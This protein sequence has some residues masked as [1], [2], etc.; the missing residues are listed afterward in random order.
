MGRGKARPYVRRAGQNTYY[1][2]S[3]FAEENDDGNEDFDD[4]Y[5]REDWE[6]ASMGVHMKNESKYDY[7]QHLRSMGTTPGAVFIPAFS[8]PHANQDQFAVKIKDEDELD[9]SGEESSEE[10]S[11]LTEYDI[12]KQEAQRKYEDEL[13]RLRAKNAELDEVMRLLEETE[14]NIDVASETRSAVPLSEEEFEL[15][16]DFVLLAGMGSAAKANGATDFGEE[17]LD[18]FEDQ[19][20]LSLEELG[21][22]ARL[23]DEQFDLLNMEYDSDM[24]DYHEGA[25][26]G[27]EDDKDYGDADYDDERDEDLLQRLGGENAVD[28]LLKDCIKLKIDKPEEGHYRYELSEDEKVNLKEKYKYESG[29][30][31]GW[32]SDPFLES[33]EIAA[34]AASKK[35]QWDCETILTTYTNTENHPSVIGLPR[36][37]RNNN[38]KMKPRNEMLIE[39]ESDSESSDDNQFLESN[40]GDFV[41][42]ASFKKDRVRGESK[43][44]KKLRKAA[45]KEEKRIRRMQ[46]ASTKA[47]FR[48]ENS[49]QSKQSAQMGTSKIV[50]QFS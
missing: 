3:S 4:E 15:E 12:L 36:K 47:A 28:Q 1:V 17:Y 48:V 23:L 29:S 37:I 9:K 49:R 39:N 31:H 35:E 13:R 21:R 27:Y 33:L 24:D 45:V 22:Q 5:N 34:E 14:E 6:V 40:D 20:N 18:E 32:E 44:D 16:D 10:D 11:E 50:V 7:S 38:D 25:D 46:K 26:V 41:G 42:G 19:Q 43:E 2:V 8:N 30:E